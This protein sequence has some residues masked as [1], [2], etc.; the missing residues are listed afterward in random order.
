MKVNVAA[1]CNV[2]GDRSENAQYGAEHLT[3]PPADE[4]TT[5]LLLTGLIQLTLQPQ[6]CLHHSPMKL[7]YYVHPLYLPT[8]LRIIC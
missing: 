3:M 6:L 4:R 2:Y 8:N 1:Y 7:G 5:V